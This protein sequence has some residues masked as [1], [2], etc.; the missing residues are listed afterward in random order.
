[1]NELSTRLRQLHDH[2]AEQVNL[3]VAE[4]RDDLIEAL[5]EEFTTAATALQRAGARLDAA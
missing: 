2:Y 1:M 4:D 5:S 3:A